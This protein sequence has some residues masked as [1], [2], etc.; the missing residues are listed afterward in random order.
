MQ[1]RSNHPILDAAD[2]AAAKAAGREILARAS[3]AARQRFMTP[4]DLKS[5]VYQT[6]QREAQ[7]WQATVDAGGT[8]EPADFP[9]LKA[10]AERLAPGAPDYQG[11]ADEWNALAAAWL[12]AGPAIENLYEAAVEAV[13]A[14]TTAEEVLAATRVVWPTPGSNEG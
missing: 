13:S 3:E 6:K 14:A 10:R 4:G 2:L 12:T 9:F 1:S 8:P 11:V 7:A 5:A